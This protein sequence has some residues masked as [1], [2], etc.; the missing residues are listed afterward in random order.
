MKNI[1]S[2]LSVLVVMSSCDHPDSGQLIK[3]TTWRARNIANGHLFIVEND[4]EL[5]FKT[6]DTVCVGNS[7]TSNS[8][9]TIMNTAQL[10]IDTIQYDMYIENGDTTFNA[11]ECHN[12]ILLQKVMKYK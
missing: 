6:G 10:G 2:L 12:V 1:L 5:P 8:E 9:F 11:W 4:L 3:S 7:H